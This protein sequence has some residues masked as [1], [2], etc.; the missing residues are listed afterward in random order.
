MWVLCIINTSYLRCVQQVF[1]NWQMA[2]SHHIINIIIGL[3]VHVVPTSKNLTQ[4][5]KQTHSK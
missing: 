2:K 5:K 4:E 3:C 1:A